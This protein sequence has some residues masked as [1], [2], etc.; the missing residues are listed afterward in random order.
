MFDSFYDKDGNEWQTKAL[1]CILGRYDIGDRVPS[2]LFPHQMK[3]FGG[4]RNVD[5]F[6]T[7]R[8]GFLAAVPAKRN[9]HLPLLDYNGGWLAAP[10]G[11]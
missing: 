2:S 3:V 7:I 5:S 10:K 11:I 9:E 8:D 4:P 6:A 1:D